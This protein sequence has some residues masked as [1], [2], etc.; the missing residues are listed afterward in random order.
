[1][2][3]WVYESAAKAFNHLVVATDD[4]RIREA[5]ESFGG[6]AVMTSP[7]HQSGTERCAEALKTCRRESG[8]GYTHVVNIQGDE[9]LL[10]KQQL[11]LLR[12]CMLEGNTEIA[13]LIRPTK[14]DNEVENPNVVKVVINADLK[15]LYFSRAPIPHT[16]NHRQDW[17][18]KNSYFIHIGIYGF[19]ADVLEALVRL[20]PTPLEIAESLEQ[21]RWLEHGFTIRTKE[22]RDHARGVDTPEDLETLNAMLRSKSSYS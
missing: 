10:K 22:T 9:P 12:D 8:I 19:R 13:T 15:A 14:D 7:K 6:V 11:R 21:L 17:I 3:Q 16:R 18:K 2:I 1:M 20:D 5:V 4:L